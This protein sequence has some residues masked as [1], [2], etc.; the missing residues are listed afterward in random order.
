MRAV[1]GKA[2]MECTPSK[3]HMINE[4]NVFFFCKL[5]GE[6]T[7]FDHFLSLYRIASLRGWLDSKMAENGGASYCEED[8]DISI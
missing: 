3:E 6:N 7:A 5:T 1:D 4:H 2:F 8:P